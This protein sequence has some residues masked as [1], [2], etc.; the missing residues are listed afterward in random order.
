VATVLKVAH[1]VVNAATQY[2]ARHRTAAKD[3][4]QYAGKAAGLAIIALI[5][6]IPRRRTSRRSLGAGHARVRLVREEGE[7]SHRSFRHAALARDRLAA[8]AVLHSIE[9][10]EKSHRSSPDVRSAAASW[11]V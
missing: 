1:G 7:Q 2:W 4:A 5:L 9:N 8:R 11:Y 6:R 3:R 10:V